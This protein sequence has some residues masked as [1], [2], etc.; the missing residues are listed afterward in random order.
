MS[1]WPMKKMKKKKSLPINVWKTA[2]KTHRTRKEAP[3]CTCIKGSMAI[4]AAVILPFLTCLFVFFL[5]FFRMIQV[6]LYVGQAVEKTGRKLAV[7]AEKENESKSAES[8][9]LYLWKAKTIFLSELSERNLLERYV[10][11]GSPGVT[12]FES[13]FGGNEIELV[14]RYEMEFPIHLFIKR[15]FLVRYQT[16]YRKWTGWDGFLWDEA[17]DIWVYIAETGKVYHK[18]P[19]CTYLNLTIKSVSEKTV[20]EYRNEDGAKYR[21]CELCSKTENIF[22]KVYI[23]SYGD[24][25]H[26][27][28]KCSGMKRTIE[29]RRLSEVE[30][31]GACS[32]CWN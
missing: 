32:K 14:A 23:T 5:F 26:K 31:M 20:S 9:I 21:S 16:R 22:G 2:E 8:E 15:P 19:S 4:E 29:M 3:G 1:L 25:Y 12:F 11:G 28:L 6:Q 18:T 17:G 27:S 30:E 10:K 7:Y 24:C 13:Q